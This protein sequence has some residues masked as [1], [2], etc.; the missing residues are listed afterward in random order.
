M[1]TL[2]GLFRKIAGASGAITRPQVERFLEDAGVGDGWFGGTKVGLAADAFF[3]KFQTSSGNLTWDA[4]M[5][6]GHQLLPANLAA[7]ADKATV[8]HEIDKLYATLD[9]DG[10]GITLD[11]LT[12]HLTALAEAK[13]QMMAGTKAELGAKIL[14]HALDDNGD[15]R[16]QKDELKGFALDVLR[17]VS[18][19]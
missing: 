8:E 17:R 12:C 1:P 18:D 10:R 13:G 4:F 7:K 9:R 5:K 3:D 11:A 16:L 2:D 6:R 14:M 19:K 15:R